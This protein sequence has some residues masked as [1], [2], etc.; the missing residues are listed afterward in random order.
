MPKSPSTLFAVALAAITLIGPLSIHLFLPAL[1]QVK[2]AF[3]ISDGLAQFTFSITLFTMAGTTL[4][5]GALSDHYG[6]RPVLL[7]G[8]TLFLVGIALA[9]WAPTIELF[10]LGRLIQAVGAGC[11]VAL[12][13]AIARDAYGPEQLVKAI[14]YLTMAYTLGPMISPP[15]GGLLVDHLGWRSTFWFAL[16]AG[17]I[18]LVCATVTLHETRPR[19]ERDGPKP[20]VLRG[21]GRLLRQP[22]FMSFVLQSGFSSGTFFGLASATTFLMTDYMHR[23][24]TEFG[25]YFLLFASGYCSGNWVSSRLSG[26]VRIEHMVLAG[27]VILAAVIAVMVTVIGFG[28]ITPLW[29]FVP[30]ALISFAQGVALPNAQAGAIRVIPELAGTAAG[31]GVFLQMFCG[32]V[33]SQLYG[34]FADGT[35]NPMLVIVSIAASLTLFCGIAAYRLSRTQRP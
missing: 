2:D 25:F 21:F 13:R 9:L 28:H 1:P 10:I 22:L 3:G 7:I 32:G 34:M 30:G 18:I 19:D 35:P 29:L 33:F 20:G 4:V 27:S 15:V 17:I 8:L 6:R 24:A 16:V 14:A 11:G 23:P 31:I 5:Y 26:R 12:A